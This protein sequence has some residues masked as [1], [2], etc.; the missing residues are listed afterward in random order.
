MKPCPNCGHEKGT[1]GPAPPPHYGKLSCAKCGRYIRFLP[2][3]H[4]QGLEPE[5]I[6]VPKPDLFSH[7]PSEEPT[8]TPAALQSPTT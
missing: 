3:E 5:E 7:L 4:L 6:A 2:V 1:V 8:V